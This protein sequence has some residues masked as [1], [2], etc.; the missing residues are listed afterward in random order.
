MGEVMRALTENRPPEISADDNLNTLRLSLAALESSRTGKAFSCRRRFRRSDPYR[1]ATT[2][3][4]TIAHTTHTLPAADAAAATTPRR[5]FGPDERRQ[6]ETEGFLVLRASSAPRRAGRHRGVAARRRPPPPRAALLAHHR[7]A[8]C[9]GRPGG[10][11]HCRCASS[12]RSRTIP[13]RC[14]TFGA[15]TP[16]AEATRE[17]LS[18]DGANPVDDLRL[19]FLSCFAKPAGH[20]T[21]TPW[22]QDQGLWSIWNPA[23][24]SCWVAIDECTPENGCLE[25]LRGSHRSGIVEH[26]MPEGSFHP[27]IPEDRIDPERVVQVPMQPGD[28]VFF[29]GRVL[30]YSPPNRSDRRRLGVVAVYSPDADLVRSID[31]SDWANN[32]IRAGSRSAPRTR[33]TRSGSGWTRPARRAPGSR[34]ARGMG[35]DTAAPHYFL[36]HWVEREM[37]PSPVMSASTA[38]R[39]LGVIAAV[40]AA[41]RGLFAVLIN[42]ATQLGGMTTGGLGLTDYGQ[43]QAIGGA[44]RR[45]YR[46]VGAFYNKDEEEWAFEPHAAQ[47]VLDGYARDAGVA[48]YPRRFLDAVERDDGGRRIRQIRLLG[49][50]TVAARVFID[51]TYEGDLLAKA[52]VSYTIGRESN[53]VYGEMLNGVQVRGKH[54]FSSFV[55]PYVVPGDPSSG[56]LPGVDQQD[57]A[58]DG[59][60]DHRLQ[61]YNFRVCL[62]DDPTLKC[63]GSS[64]SATTR[65]TTSWRAAGSTPKKTTP[66]NR[67]LRAPPSPP[68]SMRSR[69]A[70]RQGYLKTDTNNHGPGLL[71]LYRRE[72]CLAGG[73]LCPRERLFQAHVAYQ[74]GLYWT[75]ANDPAIPARYREAF[76]RF[77]LA[78]DEF[79]DTGHWPHQ[80]YVR[81]A[82]RMVSD[83]VLTEHDALHRRR[84]EDPVG[85]GSYT[86]D[87]HNCSRFVRNGRVLNEGDV[88]APPA[89]PYGVS[90][91]SIVPARGECANLLA[92]VCVSASHIAFGTVRMEP[93][94][95][96]WRRAPPSL[97]RSLS[98]GPFP[99]RMYPTRSC[100]ASSTPPARHWKMRERRTDSMFVD[101]APCSGSRRRRRRGIAGARE[102]DGYLFLRG[103]LPA[104]AVLRLR[105]DL[106]AVVG[107]HGWLANAPGAASALAPEQGRLDTDALARVPESDLRTI[108]ASPTPRMTR[109]ALESCTVCRIIRTCSRFSKRCSDGR[110]SCTRVISRPGD[111][112]PAMAPTPQHQDSR[113]SGH[114]EHWTCWFPLGDCPARWADSPFCALHRSGY[115]PIQSGAAPAPSRRSSALVTANGP[116][117]IRRGR[118]AAF[119][120]SC[121]KALP[122]GF[123]AASG[124]RSTCATS[125]PMSGRGE[126][127][128]PALRA[129][130]RRSS[131]LGARRPEV[132]L[133][134]LPL[135][136]SPWDASLL[137]PARRIC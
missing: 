32:R 26:V 80:L 63:P 86:L 10:P 131:R 118:R 1:G 56:T 85:M 111:V 67:S 119:P 75:L 9:A 52:G 97:P 28:A 123:R 104:D 130:G 29:D 71:G 43:K 70:R 41:R 99:S 18:G 4:D 136:L 98:G 135:T 14:A 27:Y 87:S 77:G 48:V 66:T 73:G 113:S 78:R 82:R 92:P 19:M 122:S 137:Q 110:C 17:L 132:L 25:F 13:R 11:A 128:P 127:A 89:G 12:R 53:K 90:Y 124:C 101:S 95:W 72:L 46:D 83:Y 133:A 44:A 24:T 61:A 107:R 108:S 103:L 120:V 57:A 100:G 16:A 40:T 35:D 34:S 96:R 22:H 105:S 68:S 51:G 49:G 134:T 8:G 3:D 6:Y 39:R 54:Q 129:R 42:P 116:R 121:H 115:I 36:P 31:I 79:T 55:D 2:Y 62:T 15:G 47:A 117:T 126:V 64:P 112:A 65:A 5:F 33:F 74:K 76:G 91:R 60:G 21:E 81:E 23:A 84:C 50:L 94:L 114:H 58:P 125:R 88:Q 93:F 20:G 45:F 59:S 7:G 38:A 37:K 109:A 30:H 69:R 106:L 102:Q